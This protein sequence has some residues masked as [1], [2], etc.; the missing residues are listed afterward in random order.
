VWLFLAEAVVAR[1]VWA[2]SSGVLAAHQ[3][4]GVELYPKQDQLA[5]RPESVIRMPS[6]VHRLTGRGYVLAV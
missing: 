2:Y 4:G 5:D 1:E 3:V 6:G